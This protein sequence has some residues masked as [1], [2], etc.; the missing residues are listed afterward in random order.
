MALRL[1][2]L[3]PLHTLTLERAFSIMRCLLLL[4]LSPI[5]FVSSCAPSLGSMTVV[6]RNE[7]DV[8][9][10][11]ELVEV[12][13]SDIQRRL[14]LPIGQ[15]PIIKDEKGETIPVQAS[16]DGDLLFPATV[17]AHTT[18]RYTIVNAPFPLDRRSQ[19]SAKRQKAGLHDD[20]LE[21]KNSTMCCRIRA[22]YGQGR[23]TEKRQ[24]FPVLNGEELSR[25]GIFLEEDIVD[26]DSLLHLEGE[27]DYEILENGPLRLVLRLRSPALQ[28]ANGTMLKECRLTMEAGEKMCRAEIR[29]RQMKNAIH[30][31]VWLATR[32]RDFSLTSM[33]EGSG[34]MATEIVSDS[35][36]AKGGDGLFAACLFMEPPLRMEQVSQERD[37]KGKRIQALTALC[38][39][40]SLT[41][42]FG[43][44]R[45]RQEH[46]TWEDWN[47][48]LARF[49]YKKRC[50]L[51]AS[52][53]SK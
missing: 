44:E 26:G 10:E 46:A 38:P 9:R 33:Q 28:T 23:K 48:Y 37:G 36:G 45:A 42:Y 29:F 21:M 31:A 52:I 50:P 15:L 16:E 22:W 4:F 25:S 20:W 11:G 3:C 2:F 18:A 49:I 6:V 53:L 40:T 17:E 24:I 34:I 41:Y 32:E 51:R 47:R 35:A 27:E 13:L 43:V 5:I 8:S 12:P 14:Q 30:Y 19:L 7:S 39:K 1:L